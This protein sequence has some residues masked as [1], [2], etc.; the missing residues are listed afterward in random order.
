MKRYLFEIKCAGLAALL[1]AIVCVS[2][3]LA[4]LSGGVGGFPGPGTAHTAT[5]GPTFTFR[6]S[7]STTAAGA[8]ISTSVDI[9]TASADRLIIVS[10]MYGTTGVAV[11]S[12][13]VN[14]TSLTADENGTL[15][16]AIYSGLVT[17]GS[18]PQNVT[19]TW[20][21]GS[22]NNRGFALWTATGL[23]SNLVKQHTNFST[24]SG[25]ISVTA[26]DFMVGSFFSSGGTSTWAGSTEAPTVRTVFSPS[27]SGQAPEWNTIASTNAAFSAD[28]TGSAGN[29]ALAT[30]R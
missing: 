19:V 25:T 30:Y 21:S 2:T 27:P 23:N 4:Q 22:F 9:G 29:T 13:T 1:V 20:A 17:T 7:A 6:N 28:H 15:G 5:A 18:G 12:I 10:A 3:S 16:V 26:G 11:T 8:A 14:G 24:I